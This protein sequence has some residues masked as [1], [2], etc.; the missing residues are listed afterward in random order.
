MTR[1]AWHTAGT[2][3]RSEQACRPLVKSA[4]WQPRPPIRREIHA[5]QGHT[6]HT[7]QDQYAGLPC[8]RSHACHKARQSPLSVHPPCACSSRGHHSGSMDDLYRHPP[9]HPIPHSS[10]CHTPCAIVL[11]HGPA[12]S[13]GTCTF[14]ALLGT[15]ES[16]GG[17][18][19]CWICRRLPLHEGTQR[20]ASMEQVCNLSTQHGLPTERS[21]RADRKA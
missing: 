7:S 10:T 20:A 8:A 15:V 16:S 19:Q 17:L 4:D 13:L 2:H 6:H 12:H 1:P 9:H 14:N 21:S 3:L 18:M 11:M 5:N